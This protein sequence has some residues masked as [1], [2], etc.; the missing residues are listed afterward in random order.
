MQ[1]GPESSTTAAVPV[2]QGKPWEAA[3]VAFRAEIKNFIA[4]VTTV[5]ALLQAEWRWRRKIRVVS[6]GSHLIPQGNLLMP[7]RVSVECNRGCGYSTAQTQQGT[8]HSRLLCNSP[9]ETHLGLSVSGKAVVACFSVRYGCQLSS[10]SKS[11]DR[12]FKTETWA[13]SDQLEEMKWHCWKFVQ[14]KPTFM[15]H[16]HQPIC[17]W[18]GLDC[19]PVQLFSKIPCAV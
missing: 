5:A 13:S 8:I 16:R 18:R 15:G 17:G 9:D 7:F 12:E 2:V 1:S 4:T 14:G 11:A 3:Q 6:M 19:Q 10:E